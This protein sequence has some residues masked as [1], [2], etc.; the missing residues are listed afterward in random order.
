M[1]SDRVLITGGSGFIGGRL[2]EILAASGTLIR[3]ATSDFRHCSRVARFPVELVKASLVDHAALAEAAVGCDV[4]FHF[5]YTWQHRKA[6]VD[7]TRV[8]AEAFLK[9]GG[10]RFVHISSVSAYGR[11]RDGGL[12]EKALQQRGDVY[13]NTKLKIE[14]LLR[15]LH[16]SRGLPVTI[17]QPTVVYGPYGSTWTTRLLEQVRSSRIAL[18]AGG[19][20]L[21][22]AVYVDDV[23]TA[24]ILAAESNAAVG[25]AFLVSGPE[26]VTWREFY[27]AYEKMMGKEAV[28]EL[29]EDTVSNEKR[30]QRRHSSLYAH[31]WRE[32]SSR[33]DLR[34]DMLR[35]PPLSWLVGAT[36]RLP[37]PAQARLK[38][39]YQSLWERQSPSAPNLPP[40]YFPDAATR[41]LYAARTR[42]C[43]AKAQKVLGYKPVFSFDR[44]M[45]LTREWARWANLVPGT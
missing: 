3:V 4:V 11:P 15:G 2:V 21:C 27:G 44:G 8:L 7:G 12:D 26:P 18:P 43:I 39:Y 45:T 19:A 40:L 17:V 16:K 25:E 37:A 28:V 13:S 5:A 9:N 10:R 30:I 1:G 20:G 29:D 33:R 42:V 6:N 41:A 38:A 36:E 22:N 35:R 24:C 31:L 14:R 32:L 23:V 34:Q